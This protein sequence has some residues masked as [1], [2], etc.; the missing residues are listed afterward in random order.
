MGYNRSAMKLYFTG[1]VGGIIQYEV[2]GQ[3]R[4]RSCP[5]TVR[6]PRT[7]AQTDHRNRFALAS[8]YVR[9][10]GDVYKVGY[11]D[12]NTSIS[13]RAN[14]VKQVYDNAL[15]PAGTIDPLKVLTARGPI[16]R[17][18]GLQLQQL[19]NQLR[20]TWFRPSNHKLKLTL[21]LYNYTRAIAQTHYDLATSQATTATIPIPDGW[22]SDTL[23]LYAFWRS[24]RSHSTSDSTAT[25]LADP[26]NTPDLIT[27]TTTA[28]PQSPTPDQSALN[29]QSLTARWPSYTT[30]SSPPPPTPPDT[31]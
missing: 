25:P 17:P 20:I 1:Q 13:Q 4:V 27:T 22:Q 6:N 14:I 15:T 24:D 3:L 9:S 21:T 10:L 23:Y 29:R 11:R 7:P 30:T 26:D 19:G 5:E 8:S 2:R 18:Q 28:N 16:T 31:P 12:Y